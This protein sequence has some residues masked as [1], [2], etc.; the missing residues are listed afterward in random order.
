MLYRAFSNRV[1]DFFT[2]IVPFRQVSKR[3]APAI[4]SCIS[5]LWLIVRRLVVRVQNDRELFWLWSLSRL[6]PIVFPYLFARY[7]CLL[8]RIGYGHGRRINTGSIILHQ[9][10]FHAVF[11]Y[12]PIVIP[13]RQPT[14]LEFPSIPSIHN[15]R[16]WILTIPLV[17]EAQNDWDIFRVLRSQPHLIPVVF[18]YLFTRYLHRGITAATSSCTLS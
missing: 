3:E 8:E 13:L 2:F 16:Y 15:P 11:Y 6:I 1:S 7:L 12:V 5:P 4:P 17:I 18:P 9:V 14:K 10:L